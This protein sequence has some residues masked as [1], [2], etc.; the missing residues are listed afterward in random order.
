MLQSWDAR[1]ESV[2]SCYMDRYMFCDVLQIWL[3]VPCMESI[4]LVAHMGLYA[5]VKWEAKLDSVMVTLFV[6][7]GMKYTCQT[8]ES[9]N[10]NN[11]RRILEVHMPGWKTKSWKETCQAGTPNPGN[12]HARLENQI[13]ET[14][15]PGWNTKSWKQTC[16][17][18]KPNPGNKHARV[19]KPDSGVH[20]SVQSPFSGGPSLFYTLYNVQ[21]FHWASY[22]YLSLQP[23]SNPNCPR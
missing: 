4:C 11:I 13:L 5:H 6:G 18:G 20:L 23:F 15:M 1:M 9:K 17:A 14:N 8:G 3:K 2:P 7:N 21:R 10:I 16:Q 22:K 19:G 12:K